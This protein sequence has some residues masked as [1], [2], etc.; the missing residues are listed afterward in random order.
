VLK[1]TFHGTTEIDAAP[2]VVNEISV[3]GSRC[4][5]FAPAL[6]LLKT[7]AVEVDSLISEELDLVDGVRAMQLAAE[8]GVMKVLL[9]P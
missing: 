5:R 8:S 3:I 4:G 6:E 7:G 1:S 2:L 9:R